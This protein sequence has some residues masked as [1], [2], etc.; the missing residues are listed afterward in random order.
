M[1]RSVIQEPRVMIERLSPYFAT[2][3][4]GYESDKPE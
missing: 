4:T 2:L 3:H 1:K